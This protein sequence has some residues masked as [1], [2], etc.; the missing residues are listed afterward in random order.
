MAGEIEMSVILLH[1]CMK[2]M[3]IL[4]WYYVLQIANATWAGF[5]LQPT[6]GNKEKPKAWGGG[7]VGLKKK[8]MEKTEMPLP[9]A[10][11]PFPIG[12]PANAMN[13]K[14]GARKWDISK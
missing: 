13:L 12:R 5:E 11:W 3:L 2:Q 10:V 4:H 6:T 7:G 14:L 1:N 8:S 9:R